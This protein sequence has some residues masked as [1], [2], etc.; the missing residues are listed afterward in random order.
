MCNKAAM[1]PQIAVMHSL[2]VVDTRRMGSLRS[3]SFAIKIR[4]AAIKMQTMTKKRFSRIANHNFSIIIPACK[5]K[6]RRE[7]TLRAQ[8]VQRIC[9]KCFFHPDF[10]VGIGITP[11]LRSLARGLY[12][13][14]GISPCPETFAE[15]RIPQSSTLVKGR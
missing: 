9:P 4:A 1:A 7:S 8:F 10:T 5:Q 11:I 6:I 3:V 12:R 15:M 14:S 2:R 13:R